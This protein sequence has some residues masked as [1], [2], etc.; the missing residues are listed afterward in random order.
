[1][2]P[3]RGRGDSD[4]GRGT[5]KSSALDRGDDDIA[6]ANAE[7]VAGILAEEELAPAPAVSSSSSLPVS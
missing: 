7:V 4:G 2:S 1:M 5:I 3:L 6:V